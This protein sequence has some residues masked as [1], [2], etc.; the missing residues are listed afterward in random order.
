[1]PKI[2]T[3]RFLWVAF[4]RFPLLIDKM[5]WS[6]TIFIDF[7]FYPLAALG[8]NYTRTKVILKERQIYKSLK[9]GHGKNKKNLANIGHP[10]RTLKRVR[11]KEKIGFF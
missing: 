1:M 7:V 11:F 6:L 5:T 10:K 9:T 8:S 2:Q 3:K 4:H